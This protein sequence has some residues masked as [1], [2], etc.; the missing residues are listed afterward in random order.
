MT[1]R[2]QELSVPRI[3]VGHWRGGNRVTF[4]LTMHILLAAAA[5]ADGAAFPRGETP[6]L[7]YALVGDNPTLPTLPTRLGRVRFVYRECLE[8]LA[9]FE[10]CAACRGCVGELKTAAAPAAPATPAA[11]P[12]AAAAS[13]AS[14][15]S[16]A[17][18]VFE[19]LESLES[20]AP[21]PE[22]DV[23]PMYV[24]LFFFARRFALGRHILRA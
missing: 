13:A 8:C 19:S 6:F 22:H 2:L 16:A 18:D 20:P 10:Q 9:A 1:R 7:P 11:T 23:V 15:A 12:A 3:F 24:F 14:A 21:E 17:A 5:C 4:L